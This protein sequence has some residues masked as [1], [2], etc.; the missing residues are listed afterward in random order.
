MSQKRKRWTEGK[1]VKAAE[2]YRMRDEINEK[3]GA[4]ADD[5]FKVGDVIEYAHEKAF[6]EGEVA[7]VLTYRQLLDVY[8][9]SASE[10]FRRVAISDVV[11]VKRRKK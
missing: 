3:L 1:R 4:M 6:I 7:G 11:A 10:M 2:L 9:D 8:T 5:H